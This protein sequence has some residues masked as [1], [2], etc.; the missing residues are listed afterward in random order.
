MR[1]HRSAPS[2][3]DKTLLVKHVEMDRCALIALPP[4]R[5]YYDVVFRSAQSDALVPRGASEPLSKSW[6][7]SESV[8]SFE[9]SERSRRSVSSGSS[10]GGSAGSHG[11]EVVRWGGRPGAVTRA[12]RGPATDL[13]VELPPPSRTHFSGFG[14]SYHFSCVSPFQFTYPYV[15][16]I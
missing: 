13:F 10:A 8:L 9:R 7:C 12:S 15:V 5:V 2:L 4:P 1:P 11:G 16:Y 14:K 3:L 6:R